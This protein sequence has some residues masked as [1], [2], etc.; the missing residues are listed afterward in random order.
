MAGR[1]G[2]TC[3]R[4]FQHRRGTDTWTSGGTEGAHSAWGFRLLRGDS[5]KALSPFAVHRLT[6][7]GSGPEGSDFSSL[8]AKPKALAT[9]C[10][11]CFQFSYINEDKNVSSGPQKCSLMFDSSYLPERRTPSQQHT[12]CGAG[13]RGKGAPR[14]VRGLQ[15]G[16][17]QGTGGCGWVGASG[18]VQGMSGTR[19]KQKQQQRMPTWL[20]TDLALVCY[21]HMS[22]PA[23]A[24]VCLQAR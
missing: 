9:S 21:V 11:S 12:E 7:R 2:G 4:Q 1:A 3:Q 18:W 6:H 10:C 15:R 20:I 13:R 19:G 14:R 8:D 24:S 22:E 23:G 17:A 5:A 16:V